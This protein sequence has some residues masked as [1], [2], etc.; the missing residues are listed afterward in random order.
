MEK[1]HPGSFPLLV[2]LGFG[3]MQ[4]ARGS[5]TNVSK[6]LTR[7]RVLFQRASALEPGRPEARAGLGEV[8]F[9]MGQHQRALGELDRALLLSDS[10]H[11]RSW[12][13]H[14]LFALGRVEEAEPEVQTALLACPNLIDALVL[15][16][17]ITADQ[18]RYQRAREA[19]EQVLTMDPDNTAARFN[20][21][22][23]EQS[24]VERLEQ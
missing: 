24:G 6:R 15:L 5:D 13:G 23:L 4:L 19:W 16:G 21:D 2:N 1:S 22:Q 11:Y 8:Y 20:L 12:R 10:C 14:A 18:S 17:N 7:A 9:R 3:Q